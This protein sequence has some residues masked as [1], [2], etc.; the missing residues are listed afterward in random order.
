M[1]KKNKIKLGKTN[2]EISRVI[3]GGIISSNEKQQDSDYYVSYAIDRAVNYFDVAPAYGD[4]QMKLGNSLKPYRKDICLACKTDKRDGFSAE[5]QLKESLK[6][7]HTD[8]L[9]VYQLHALTTEEDLNKAFADDGVMD[10]L[11]KAKKEG[12][13]RNLGFS[14]HNEEVALE[15]LSLYSFDTILFPF[16]WSLGIEKSMGNRLLEDAK[17]K[18]IGILALKSMAK[19]NWN[20]NEV[21]EYPKC[22]Y[23]PIEIEKQGNDNKLALAALKYTLSQGV[24]ALVPPGY[25]TYLEF[26]LDHIDDCIENAYQESDRLLLQESLEEVRNQL[27]F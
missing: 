21:R 20:E 19:R 13:I 16:N 26:V 5:I 7:L 18:D 17:R 6:L 14:A 12:I 22:W 24:H 15:A 4:A 23:K 27:I 11:I 8:Y 10:F 25:F 1:D 2:L 9:D 3:Y